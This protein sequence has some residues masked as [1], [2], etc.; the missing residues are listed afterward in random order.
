MSYAQ[1][2][3][4]HHS[5]ADVAEARIDA[6]T[7]ALEIIGYAHHEVHAGS[8][9]AVHQVEV[10]F[11]KASEIGVL[12]TTPNT[13]KWIHMLALVDCGTA[14]WFEILEAPT[15][16]TDNYPITFYTP[17]NRNR[18]HDGVTASI[19]SSVR[20]TPNADEVSLKLKGDAA[21]ITDDG[22]VVH[23]EI[24]G[25]GK[26][27]SAVG[28]RGTSEYVLKQNTTYYFR[29]K[30]LGSGADDSVAS[31]ELDWYEHTDKD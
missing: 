22:T 3:R 21:P 17:Q 28:S 25:T 6:S 27:G 11:D 12:F 10:D 14:A 29:L 31:I 2:L 24:I 1:V 20:G 4:A 8:A 30:G 9:F 23:T 16:D 13:T 15:V 26:K 18:N 7:H 5:D 19:V